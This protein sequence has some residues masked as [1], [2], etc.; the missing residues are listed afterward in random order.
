MVFDFVPNVKAEPRAAS[1]IG[2]AEKTRPRALALAAGSAEQLKRSPQSNGLVWD[3]ATQ[4]LSIEYCSVG[5]RTRHLYLTADY[6]WLTN[7]PPKV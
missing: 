6:K 4:G 7:K 2:K 3:R 5:R 1:E